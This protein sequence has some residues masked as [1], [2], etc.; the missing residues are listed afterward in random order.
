MS[1]T[2][3]TGLVVKHNNDVYLTEDQGSDVGVLMPIPTPGSGAVIDGDYWAD[4]INDNGIV[5]GF[6]FIPAKPTD[7]VKPSPQAF[8]VFRLINRFG[9]DVWYVRGTTTF[10]GES[11]ANAGYIQAAQ[12]AECCDETP[13]TLPQTAPEMYP[14][15]TSCILD[16]SEGA[17]E[18][19][20][21]LPLPRSGALFTGNGYLNG[22]ALPQVTGATPALL[23][24]ALNASW[25]NIGSPSVAITWTVTA[26]GVV[27][28][29]VTNGDGTEQLCA[30]F[31]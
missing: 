12:D 16:D 11:P 22:T 23:Q 31:V 15:Q 8:H 5:T 27:R 4:P 26:D 18:F 19:I 21:Q 30:K 6:D 13:R 7:T 24:T 2:F 28:G 20:L 14:C 3:I 25:N 9:N 29:V 17:F 1:A 10:D